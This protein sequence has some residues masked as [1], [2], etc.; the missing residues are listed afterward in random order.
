MITLLKSL[1]NLPLAV[2]IGWSVFSH[3]V[4][5]AEA[6]APSSPTP[7]TNP[8]NLSGEEQ[9]KNGSLTAAIQAWSRDIKNGKEL[10]KSLY[11][12]SQ[13][14]ILLRQYE[15]AL[16]DLNQLIKVQ[17]VRTASQVYIVR[18]VALNELNR[19]NEAIED[20]DQAEKL[21]PSVF[22]YTNRGIAYQR[23]GQL[24]KAFADLTKAAAFSPTPIAKLNLANVQIQL[25][26]YTEVVNEM[27]QLLEKEKT[28]FPAY[29][30]RSIGYYNLGQY[31]A[32]IR[33][34][35]FSLKIAPEQ[36]EA[37]YYAGLSFA[38]LNR[39]DDASQNLV[40]A[41]ELYLRLNQS[42]NYRQVL[43]KMSELNLQ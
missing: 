31:E 8:A 27:N 17:G 35:L 40:K 30:V 15:L 32:A 21:E 12:R 43:D 16:Q 26:Q 20:F 13:A 3:H 9:F 19:F 4:R 23:S 1:P 37:Y 10:E 41:A 39:K 36:P 6:Q 18:G 14:Y 11:N 38:K 22:V 34:C 5:M 2:L 24:N 33:D 25:G 29:L 28:F 42:N 7:V